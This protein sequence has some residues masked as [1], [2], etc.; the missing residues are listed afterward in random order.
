MAIG[1]D[2]SF[3]EAWLELRESFVRRL[4]RKYYG[5]EI[6]EIGIRAYKVSRKPLI[7]VLAEI[8]RKNIFESTMFRAGRRV[9]IV[10][11]RNP[12]K[13]S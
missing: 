4:A 11:R 10:L 6:S 1:N 7:A 9:R 3:Y 13:R 12:V 8:R 5:V 2:Q